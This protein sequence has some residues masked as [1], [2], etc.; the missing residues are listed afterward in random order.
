[1]QINTPFFLGGWGGGRGPFI[2]DGH[3][4]Q[5]KYGR[6]VGM[7]QFSGFIFDVNMDD[8]AKSCTL[9]E[10]IFAGINFR[11]FFFRTFRGN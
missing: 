5:S 4:L 11:E 1:M 3:F 2:G 9:R 6:F 7:N 10:E 8:P